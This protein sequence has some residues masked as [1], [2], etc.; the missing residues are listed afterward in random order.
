M[1][2]EATKI[3]VRGKMHMYTRGIKVA[4]FKS[5]VNFDLLGH[6]GCFGGCDELRGHLNGGLRQHA[7][8]YQGNRDC[9]FQ[10]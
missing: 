9:L 5:E 6:L 8:R 4:D 7:H 10:T 3:V 2:S 1:I